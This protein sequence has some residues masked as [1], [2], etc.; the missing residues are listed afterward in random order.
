LTRKTAPKLCLK[1]TARAAAKSPFACAFNRTLECS[2]AYWDALGWVHFRLGHDDTAEKYLKAGWIVS[3][4]PDEADHL[5]QVYERQHKQQEAARMYRLALAS[6]SHS[7]NDSAIQD[8]LDRLTGDERTRAAMKD[9][10]DLGETRTFTVERI[11]KETSNADFFL[12]IGSGSKVED[13]KFVSG[14]EELKSADK[15]LRAIEF[16]VP[17]PDDGP[18]RLVR[19]GILSCYPVTGCTFVLY[20]VGD[21]HSVN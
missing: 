19:R 11:T 3:Q 20:N 10:G 6:P 2:G 4:D 15:A 13:V 16:K 8:R 21:V 17:F 5:G 18:S 12:L 14:S 1:M 7:E 9:R